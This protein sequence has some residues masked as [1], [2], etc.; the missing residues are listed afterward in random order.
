LDSPGIALGGVKLV[1]E[2]DKIGLSLASSSQS[3]AFSLSTTGCQ[4]SNFYG[5]GFVYDKRRRKGGSED[6]YSDLLIK[7]EGCIQNKSTW[8]YA[9]KALS[10]QVTSPQRRQAHP[11][12]R[13]QATA[14]CRLYAHKSIILAN[15]KLMSQRICQ[16]YHCCRNNPGLC[17]D[18]RCSAPTAAIGAW[19]RSGGGV[20]EAG[21]L[22]ELD[23]ALRS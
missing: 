7:A 12:S 6:K 11:A 9:A 15:K 14:Q 13:A 4:L 1:S 19:G 5:E 16:G 21:A 3:R 2:L 10:G 20:L 23:L 18:W 22:A 17:H 8:L